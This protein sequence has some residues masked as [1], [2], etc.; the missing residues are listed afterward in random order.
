MSSLRS[1]VCAARRSAATLRQLPPALAVR[2]SEM[3][4]LV[5]VFIVALATASFVTAMHTSR[6]FF[7]VVGIAVAVMVTA[8][9]GALLAL[10]TY[11]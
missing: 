1:Q 6:L 10:A 5:V 8:G 2:E 4:I 7:Q 11:K 9:L 3:K